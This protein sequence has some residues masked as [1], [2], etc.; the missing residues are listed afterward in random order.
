[1]AKQTFTVGQILTADQ[2]T[3]LQQTAMGGGSATAKTGSYT[4]VAAD[5]GAT[6]VMN[7]A[8]VTT[9]T[10]NTSLFA[11]GDTVLIVNEGAGVCTVTAGTAT[12]STAGSLAL[13]QYETAIL[14]FLSTSAAILTDYT[15]S[16]G[17]TNPMTTTGDII[18]SSSGSTPARLGI[19]TTGQV[20][21]V[22]SGIPSWATTSSGGMTLIGTPTTLSGTTTVSITGI[23]ATYNDLVID[24]FATTQ[25]SNTDCSINPNASASITDNMRGGTTLQQLND[26][27]MRLNNNIA[28]PLSSST[29]NSWRVIITN[30]AA[31][32]NG[33]K[34]FDMYG[35]YIGSDSS[36]QIMHNRGRI[37]TTSAISSLDFVSGV[38]WT[39]GT[40]EIYGV[41]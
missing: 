16:G 38:N 24:I 22:A 3:S 35:G 19:G 15:Q 40:V 27:S 37:K 32:T 29:D 11:A 23:P 21:S 18:Y 7:S 9:I 30:Y 4:L 20:L 25:T 10:V 33:G 36:K 12:V 39:A 14:Y 28:G 1:M 41:K 2:M 31:T 34:P 8:S 17:M 6:I 13:S 26:G 5:A